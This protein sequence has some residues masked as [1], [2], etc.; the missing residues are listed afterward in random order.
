M[1]SY[2]PSNLKLKDGYGA[3]YW[4]LFESLNYFYKSICLTLLLYPKTSSS[5]NRFLAYWAFE[6]G[7]VSHIP[8][9][10]FR[11]QAPRVLGCLPMPTLDQHGIITRI[12]NL[13]EV[14]WGKELFACKI[15]CKIVIELPEQGIGALKIYLL[16]LKH[17][18][19]TSHCGWF[20][21]TDRYIEKYHYSWRNL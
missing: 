12:P 2:S 9:T 10:Q 17:L 16:K 21:C 1:F 19:A 14:H 4:L 13:S 15:K 6:N 11:R 5:S 8:H 3:N 20:I 18:L 7:G